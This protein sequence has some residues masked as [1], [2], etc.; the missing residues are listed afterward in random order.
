[1]W[2]SLAALLG[3]IEQ[4]MVFNSINF[5]FAPL[6]DYAAINSTAFNATLRTFHC[7][8]DPNAGSFNS[9]RL[10]GMGHTSTTN[11][12]SSKG[13]SSFSSGEDTSGLFCFFKS[14][15]IRDDV[16]GTSGTIAYGESAIGDFAGGNTSKGNGVLTGTSYAKGQVY[17]ATTALPTLQAGFAQCDVAFA[18]AAPLTL[19]TDQGKN[20]GHGADGVSMMNFIVTPNSKVYRWNDCKWGTGQ[21]VQQSEIQRASSYHPGGVNLLFADGSTRFIKDG[22]SQTVWLALGT[23]N[24]GEVVSADSY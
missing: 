8:S 16:D 11:Y 22:V 9:Q 21:S 19:L 5:Y 17:D 7:P 14:F 23:R 3:D 4:G 18:A 15:A 13:S 24:G 12:Q 2:G 1:M 10:V 6:G 20:W